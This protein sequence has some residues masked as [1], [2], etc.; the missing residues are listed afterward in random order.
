MAKDYYKILEV[1][2]SASQD[3]IK[4]SFRRLA[5]QYHPDKNS[6]ND[7]KF[8][9]INEAY[10]IL[11]NEEKRKQYDQFGTT[12]DNAGAGAGGQGPFGAG[13]DWSGF[14]RQGNGQQGFGGADNVNFDFSNLGD[15]FGDIF[16][17]SS[18]GSSARRTRSRAGADHEANLTIDFE[19]AVF[20]TEKLIELNKLIT[21]DECN[22]NGVEP[23]S[24]LETC[25]TCH[26]HGQVTTEQR[27]FFGVFQSTGVC[28]ACEGEGK[29]PSQKCKHCHGKGVINSTERIKIKIPEGIN[30]NETI[31][32][33]GKGD[34]G[35][36]GA[37]AG[38]LYINIKIRPSAIY[39]RRGD[40]VYTR[41]VINFSQATLGDK[42]KVKTLQGEVALKIPSGT[43]SGQEFRLSGK[44]VAHLRVR[45]KGDHLVKIEVNI[46]DRL[47]S[48]QKELLE[49]LSKEGL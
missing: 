32:L 2:R 43:H 16:G 42:I 24:K 39:E 23:G 22:G 29:I 30:Q 38:D 37:R 14:A 11:G 45:G 7:G 41:Q 20:G 12:F 1:E 15:I 40:D 36:K 3:D 5:H 44:G 18:R 8:K 21:C 34:A 31:K 28:P 49:K 35:Q 9:E 10:Q 17:Q 25:K 6:G 13:F 27:T 19:E 26:G 46:P 33:S 47:T 48:N 4:K